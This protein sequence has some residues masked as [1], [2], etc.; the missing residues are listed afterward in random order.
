MQ[1]HVLSPLRCEK[2][3]SFAGLNRRSTSGFRLRLQ[4]RSCCRT[5]RMTDTWTR[6]IPAA[7]RS[8][9]VE[10]NACH[11]ALC[12]RGSLSPSV[13]GEFCWTSTRA[14]RPNQVQNSCCCSQHQR[15]VVL[16]PTSFQ[17]FFCFSGGWDRVVR[18][19][20]RRPVRSL[21]WI[22][23]RHQRRKRSEHRRISLTSIFRRSGSLVGLSLGLFCLGS[24]A[25]FNSQ[26][27]SETIK[28]CATGLFRLPRSLFYYE[29]LESGGR[30]S[31]GKHWG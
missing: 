7:G 1:D 11:V 31:T 24:L 13:R 22:Y 8:S 14:K 25:Y 12:S 9:A 4:R 26:L 23:H 29:Y 20:S 10:L 16:H 19:L 30:V 6:S 27:Q 3:G 28:R 18:S 15:L 2:T 21:V 5:L 17:N